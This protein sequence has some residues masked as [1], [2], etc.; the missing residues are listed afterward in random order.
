MIDKKERSSIMDDPSE[1]VGEVNVYTFG[2][3]CRDNSVADF[4]GT[5][6]DSIVEGWGCVAQMFWC[7]NPTP[8]YP[9]GKPLCEL[10]TS[11]V[12]CFV[13]HKNDRLVTIGPDNSVLPTKKVD[14]IVVRIDTTLKSTQSFFEKLR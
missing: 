5:G 4:I 6:P 3:G 13:P 8:E 1:L 2:S 12:A 11:G 10:K 9:V 14:H 7:D